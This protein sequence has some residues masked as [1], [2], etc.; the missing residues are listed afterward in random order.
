MR[1]DKRDH[2]CKVYVKLESLVSDSHVPEDFCLMKIFPRLV[3]KNTS[4]CL[5]GVLKTKINGF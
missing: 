4:T 5:F 1:P 2:I 3:R